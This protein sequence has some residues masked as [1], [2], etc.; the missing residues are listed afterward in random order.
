MA[1]VSRTPWW[2][3][4]FVPAHMWLYRA[5]GGRVGHRLGRQRTLLLTT[6]GR[7][8]GQPRTQPVTY[9]ALEGQTVLVASNWGNDGPPAWFLNCLAHPRV[10]VRLSRVVYDAQARVATEAERARLWPRVV[11]ANPQYARYQAAVAHTIPVVLL[12]PA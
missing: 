12:L 1:T 5:S 9:F 10:R 4:W 3:R 2:A 6:T 7:R 8:T 11:A